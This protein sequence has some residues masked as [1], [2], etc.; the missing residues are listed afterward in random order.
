MKRI[1]GSGVEKDLATNRSS[2][3]QEQLLLGVAAGATTT[4]RSRPYCVKWANDLQPL[5]VCPSGK[6]WPAFKQRSVQNVPFPNIRNAGR[7]GTGG[8]ALW[9][10]T[11]VLN[12]QHV[13]GL[14]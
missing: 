2:Y 1:L 11:S 4:N 7:G 9:P 6:L 14:L 13:A 8:G 5:T 10:S 12:R 3:Y